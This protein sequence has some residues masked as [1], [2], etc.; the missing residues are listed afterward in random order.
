MLGLRTYLPTEER[1][2]RF[3]QGQFALSLAFCFA[4][5]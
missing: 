4:E 3:G 1:N 2:D 5:K